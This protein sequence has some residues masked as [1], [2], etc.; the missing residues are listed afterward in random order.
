V[1]SLA[2]VTVKAEAATDHRHA[3]GGRRGSLLA[4]FDRAL[5]AMG[6]W[7]ATAVVIAIAIVLVIALHA[8]IGVLF[9][10]RIDA[11]TLAI[12]AAVTVLVG[13]PIVVYAQLLIRKLRSSHRTLRQMTEKLALALDE[14]EAANRAK[15]GFLA[16]MSH[17]LRTPLNAI[18]GF[19]EIM[20]DELLGPLGTAQ[21]AG[22]ADDI[23]R[24]GQHLLRIISD[25]LDL[26]K[27]QSGTL[28]TDGEGEC[29]VDAII[30]D[31]LRMMS[32]IA[33]RQGVAIEHAAQARSASLVAVDRMVR[34]LL[35]NLVSNAVK[36]TPEGGRVSVATRLDPAGD[37]VLAVTDT[38]IGMSAAEVAIALTPFGQ[39]NVALN[40]KHAG[41]GL[42]LPLAKAMAELHD[43]AL[44]IDS[45]PGEGTTVAIRF[46]RARLVRHGAQPGARLAS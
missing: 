31:V 8:A 33:E 40:R 2:K 42:G 6:L 35:L 17:E 1:L 25:I 32:P 9:A 13:G 7:Q 21:Y 20:R 38:G 10:G 43:G 12:A 4:R 27:I 29:D 46:P 30:H 34:Q 44:E 36:F 19:S 39:V 37:F 16:N 24:S 15:L 45:V 28:S 23:N 5:A 14:A 3:A 22:Y 18:I 41:T 26:A 11:A